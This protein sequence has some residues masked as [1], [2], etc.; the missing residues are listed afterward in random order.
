MM[1]NVKNLIKDVNLQDESCS[2]V[3]GISQKS[4]SLSNDKKRAFE[5]TF[6]LINS[7]S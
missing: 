3:T 6:E 7:C 4:Y 2:L 5:L 1:K